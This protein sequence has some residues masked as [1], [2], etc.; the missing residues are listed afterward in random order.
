MTKRA[1]HKRRRERDLQIE[2][3]TKRIRAF[4][5]LV[6]KLKEAAK[7]W[8]SD[9][10]YDVVSPIQKCHDHAAELKDLLKEVE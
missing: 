10:C 7:R 6:G 1:T 3:Y 4:N 9:D 8:E 2:A 5:R